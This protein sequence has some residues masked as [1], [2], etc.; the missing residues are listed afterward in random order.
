MDQTVPL[1]HGADGPCVVLCDL[2][3]VVWLSHEPITGSVDAIARLRAAGHRVLF[4][5][6]NSSA[7]VEVQ[8]AA[9]DAIGI[10]A[11]GD[12]LTSAN[13]AALLIEPGERVLICG[14]EGVV[15]AVIGRG[16][17]VVANDDDDDV[18]AV[19]VG[20]HRTFDYDAMSRASRAARNGARLIGTNDD[21]TY[22]TP[23]GPIPGGGAILASIVTASGVVP[24]V[25]GK[26]H[27]PMAALVRTTI[28]ESA[29]KNAVMVG[30]RPETDG[31]M[32][33][34]LGCHYAHVESGITAPGSTV[35]PTPDLIA[36]NLAGVA[37]VLIGQAE[38]NGK[39][40][41]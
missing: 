20:F 40:H 6:N 12:V 13:A 18:D 2:D 26:P 16:A 28:G 33:T 21:A 37:E 7:R 4:V 38:A 30:D 23:D 25:A 19:V 10:P 32:A 24:I 1:D 15:Q 39:L 9:L 22:P 11:A 36:A 31:L 41:V 14:G 17:V 3:G 5:T 35:V 34:T 29:A 8:E 27:E